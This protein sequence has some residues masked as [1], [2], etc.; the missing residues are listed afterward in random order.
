M[1]KEMTDKQLEFL[2]ANALKMKS[3][4]EM[5]GAA[6]EEEGWGEM[7]ERHE[8]RMEK[9]FRRARFFER[10]DGVFSRRVRLGGIAGIDEVA[11]LDNE[12]REESSNMKK[13]MVFCGFMVIA[14]VVTMGVLLLTNG[15][16]GLPN[17]HGQG[18]QPQEQKRQIQS[19]IMEEVVV[20]VNS[21]AEVLLFHAYGRELPIPIVQNDY[22]QFAGGR[23]MQ[24]DYLRFDRG[25]S[26]YFAMN[27]ETQQFFSVGGVGIV[28]TNA[29]GERF[30]RM[31]NTPRVSW[32]GGVEWWNNSLETGV[33]YRTYADG[34]IRE[35]NKVTITYNMGDCLTTRTP[36]P[37]AFTAETYR[38]LYARLREL[39]EEGAM[40]EHDARS[41]NSF[42]LHHRHFTYW[43]VSQVRQRADQGISV[44]F[45]P[46]YFLEKYPNFPDLGEIYVLHPIALSTMSVFYRLYDLAGFGVEEMQAELVKLGA[47]PYA[48]R[49]FTVALVYELYGNSLLVYLDT[50]RTV[51]PEG[52]TLEKIV[53]EDAFSAEDV[54]FPADGSV[55]ARFV[56]PGHEIE[57]DAAGIVR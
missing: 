15:D 30:E 4:S 48:P 20:A 19:I 43:Q 7:S 26:S 44:E 33:Q 9:L 22:L 24:D 35:T 27:L 17:S 6:V 45:C 29:D 18:E 56:F 51:M 32:D 55:M 49:T 11:T 52:Y 5:V 13:I 25:T 31:V 46:S 21:D 3:E 54:Y 16:G 42:S 23:V 40:A 34:S 2:L 14:A 38:A 41:M 12:Y 53:W 8:L 36:F 37:L 39:I 10:V 28:Y 57:G 50:E 1:R 47:E